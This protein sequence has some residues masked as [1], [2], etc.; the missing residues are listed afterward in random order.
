MSTTYPDLTNTNF[1]ESVDTFVQM[2]DI[3]A[4][5]ATA[6]KAYQTA[7]ES[8]NISQANSAIA[9]MANGAQKILTAEKINK[10]F[11]SIEALERFLAS[12]IVPYINGLQS[13][14]T[15]E[16]NK[17]SYI[18]AYN[19][20]TSYSK[21]N[22]VSNVVD[23]ENT[24]LYLRIQDG[25]AGIPVSNSTYWKQFTIPG[26][27]GESGIGMSFRYDW[28][29]STQYYANDCVLYDGKLWGAK[30]G[31]TGHTPSSSP[32][33]WQEVMGFSAAQYPIQSTEPYNQE[34]GDLWFQT[35]GSA[36]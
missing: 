22:I 26:I 34:T 4:S 15:S 13:N 2:L 3:V 25:G 21:N 9:S 5:D 29:A 11:D 6:L 35:I 17:F 30:T 20:G 16:M 12:D 27:K 10:I 18:G 7:M 1:P 32:S 14:W 36:L 33:Y 8:G 31:G 28:D 23:A 19:S 24:Y